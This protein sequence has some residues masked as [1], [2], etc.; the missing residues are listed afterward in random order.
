SLDAKIE[1]GNATSEDRDHHLK[2][3]Q[4][5]DKLDNLEVV[6]SIQ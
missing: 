2:L 6:D 5:I 4:K 3:L 1:A